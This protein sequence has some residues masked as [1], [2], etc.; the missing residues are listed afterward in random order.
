MTLAIAH[1]EMREG[2]RWAVLDLLREVKPPFAPTQ[3]VSDFSAELRRYHVSQ[4][5]GD[6]YGAEWVAEAFRTA[7]I[8]YTAAEKPKSDLYRE[9]LGPL[10]SGTVELLDHPRLIAQLVGL[11]RRVARGGRES[12]DHA[13]G[14]HDDLANAAAGVLQAV[15]RKRMVGWE[16]YD[17]G[18]LYYDEH[19]NPRDGGGSYN[20]PQGIL[21]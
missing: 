17:D 19:G 16:I 3:V 18:G 15:G 14:A 11:E 10:N 1:E 13:P 8:T 20:P 21:G 9:L 6:R 4:V 12:I 7:G 5:I 2:T